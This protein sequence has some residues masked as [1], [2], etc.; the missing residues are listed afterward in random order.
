MKSWIF[1]QTNDAV[2]SK[3][4]FRLYLASYEDKF[5]NVLKKKIK[6]TIMWIIFIHASYKM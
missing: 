5:K 4:S 6:I 2:E 3:F 1:S